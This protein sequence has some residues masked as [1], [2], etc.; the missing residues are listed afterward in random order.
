MLRLSHHNDKKMIDSHL[1]RIANHLN[2]VFL[3]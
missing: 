2:D 1:S 3:F